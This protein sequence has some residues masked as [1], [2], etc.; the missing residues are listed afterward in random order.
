MQH[1]FPKKNNNRNILHNKYF[2]LPVSMKT[3]SFQFVAWKYFANFRLVIIDQVTYRRKI[4]CMIVGI[5]LLIILKL[6][7]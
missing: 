5:F 2:D 1:P 4:I 7:L 3:Q 6:L